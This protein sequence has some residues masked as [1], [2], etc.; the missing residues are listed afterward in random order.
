MAVLSMAENLED[1]KIRL[2]NIMVALDKNGKPLYARDFKAEDAMTILL[3]DAIYPN[4]VQTLA[5]TPAL[6]HCG[7]FANIAHGCNSVRA[8]RL[9]LSFADYV[10]TEAGFGADL[11]AEKFLDFKCRVAGLKPNCVV[12]V[13]TIK[14]L[15]LHGG[16]D[17]Q[18]LEK[19]NLEFVEK[20]LS[21]LL[22]HINVIK[23]VFKLP[24]VVTLNKYATD[25]PAEIELVKSRVKEANVVIDDVWSKGGK[26]ASELAKE[27]V[28]AC[29]QN[30]S[31]FKFCYNLNQSVEEKINAIVNKV[32]GGKAVV[33]SKLAKEKLM[34]IKKFNLEQLPII[35]AKTQFSLSDDK[36]LIG[37]PK[38]FVIEVRDIEIRTGAEFLVVV[39]GKML[40]MPALSKSPA[41]E[42]MTIDK[43]GKID[44]LF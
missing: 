5:G 1:L 22:H 39:C 13:A 36:N 21:N 4:L 20:G 10:V 25:T 30:N 6:V 42:R 12:L 14:A 43:N 37:A 44:G 19:E 28:Y 34:T 33:F 11:G 2:G 26:G 16:A 15:K 3:K 9:A 23:S 24:L 18:S 7:P 38:D 17:E 40:L 27:V 35:M 31:N 32:Y 41:S 29:E 8:T